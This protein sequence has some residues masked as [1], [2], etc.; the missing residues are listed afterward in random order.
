[1]ASRE[2]SDKAG[3]G[4]VTEVANVGIVRPPLVFLGAMALGLVLQF[5]WPVRLVPR[6]VGVPLGGAIVCV[7]VALFLPVVR[8][9]RAAG[10]PVPG[11][12]PTTTIVRTAPIATAAIPSICRSRSSSS[13]SPAGAT[14]SGSSSPSC[15]RWR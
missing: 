2:R 12:R 13:A 10:T 4:L 15:R 3:R 7:A 8:T 14:A 11:S 9:F 1:M 6:A 5:A